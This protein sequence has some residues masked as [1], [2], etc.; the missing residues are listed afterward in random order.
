MISDYMTRLPYFANDIWPLSYVPANQKEGGVDI[1]ICQHVEKTKR[2]RIVGTVVIRER[3]LLRIGVYSSESFA[4]P[5][6]GRRH[7]LVRR[8]R[9]D[10]DS[11]GGAQGAEH[12]GIVMDGGLEIA[13]LRFQI[14]DLRFQIRNSD[15]VHNRRR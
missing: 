6:R 3:Q 12:G 10:T 4:V 8:G 1:V 5:L 14:S 13:D 2:V 15:S 7:G 11:S 9:S